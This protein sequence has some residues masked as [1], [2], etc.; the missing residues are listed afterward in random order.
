MKFATQSLEQGTQNSDPDSWKVSHA[1]VGK[2]FDSWT[3]S[4]KFDT[5]N[6]NGCGTINVYNGRRC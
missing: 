5:Y 2:A 3:S 1:T 4:E 6:N